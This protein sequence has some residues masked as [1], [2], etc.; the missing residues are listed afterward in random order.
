MGGPTLVHPDDIPFAIATPG[1]WCRFRNH[2][3]NLEEMVGQPQLVDEHTPLPDF[4]E[5][6]RSV[7]QAQEAE[8]LTANLL[9]LSEDTAVGGK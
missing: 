3:E 1:I 5:E 8:T 9:S 6:A 7:C 2:V 4:P